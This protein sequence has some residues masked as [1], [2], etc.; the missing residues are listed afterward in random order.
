MI[1]LETITTMP[2]AYYVAPLIAMVG[3]LC[4]SAPERVRTLKTQWLQSSPLML[5]GGILMFLGGMS[6]LDSTALSRDN[7]INVILNVMGWILLIKASMM[8]ALPQITEQL[9]QKITP[10]QYIQIIS[11]AG[12]AY[13]LLGLAMQIQLLFW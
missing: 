8:I 5:I 12:I 1:M 10:T 13:L 7:W 11:V 4:A 6:L 9:S 2:A 3:L